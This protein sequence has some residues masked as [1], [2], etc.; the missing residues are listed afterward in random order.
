MAPLEKFRRENFEGLCKIQKRMIIQSNFS[1]E[2]LF[3]D[4]HSS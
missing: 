2:A 1:I 3:G 4:D